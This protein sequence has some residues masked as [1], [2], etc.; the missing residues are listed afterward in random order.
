MIEI[1]RSTSASQ[2]IMRR[3]AA[4]WCRTKRFGDRIVARVTPFGSEF[5]HSTKS[6]RVVEINLIDKT[7]Q[8]VSLD[9]G[10]ECGA[11]SWGRLCSHVFRVLQQIEKNSKRGT[12]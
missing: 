4:M 11:N 7:A 6:K 9:T 2:H 1:T 12:A 10:E 5:G 8:C 3:S